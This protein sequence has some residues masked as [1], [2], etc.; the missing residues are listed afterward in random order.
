MTASVRRNAPGDLDAIDLEVT[1]PYPVERVWR[2][3]TDPRALAAWLMPNDFAARVSHEFTFR[4]DPVP[5][6]DG[7]VHC[8]VLA[9]EPPRRLVYS[10]HGVTDLPETTVSFQL[11]PVAEGTRLRLLHSGFAAD[12]ALGPIRDI[13]AGGWSSRLLA[14]TLPD[15]LG[16]LAAEDH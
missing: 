3:L 4:S 16:R 11:D 14:V 6:W 5:G 15:L 12:P 13:L 1:Y 2:A 7:V 10:W 8:R 9:C